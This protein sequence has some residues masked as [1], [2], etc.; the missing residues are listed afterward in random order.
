M[1][2]THKTMSGIQLLKK[3]VGLPLSPGTE[4]SVQKF[5]HDLAQKTKDKVQ[6]TDKAYLQKEAK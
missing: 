5:G 6:N 1:A 4:S 2:R 3:A